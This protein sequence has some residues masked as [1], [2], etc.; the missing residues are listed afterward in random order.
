MSGFGLICLPFF[1]TK[2]FN[3]GINDGVSNFL[4]SLRSFI[5]KGNSNVSKLYHCTR[6]VLSCRYW[7]WGN[8]IRLDAKVSSTNSVQ[9]L[10]VRVTL[11]NSW[12]SL[13]KVDLTSSVVSLNGHISNT[14]KFLKV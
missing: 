6:L 12:K 9:L 8:M 5:V 10:L 7:K 3:Y 13:V 1:Q 4:L 14:F 2:T 11:S